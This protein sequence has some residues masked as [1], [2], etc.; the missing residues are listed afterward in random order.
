MIS[1]LA[2]DQRDS[3]ARQEK[4]GV[5]VLTLPDVVLDNHLLPALRQVDAL[6]AFALTSRPANRAVTQWRVRENLKE[7][8]AG[9]VFKVPEALDEPAQGAIRAISAPPSEPLG[10]QGVALRALQ[11]MHRF[12]N[13]PR[14]PLDLEALRQEPMAPPAQLMACL[15]NLRAGASARMDVGSIGQRGKLLGRDF[16]T[17][18]DHYLL[19][20]CTWAFENRPTSAD[21][22]AVAGRLLVQVFRHDARLDLAFRQIESVPPIGAYD[23][24][25]RKARSFRA[26]I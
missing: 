7:I 12:L 23:R 17:L 22:I 8:A 2:P 6:D 5:D 16:Q 4:P 24:T 11:R 3:A 10:R 26:G 18:R 20:L 19:P 1:P 9:L 13:T 15:E 21:P 25:G 14:T